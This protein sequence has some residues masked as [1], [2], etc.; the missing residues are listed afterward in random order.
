MIQAKPVD[1][2]VAFLL[3]H[4]PPPMHL[5]IATRED[6]PL[7]PSRLRAR[8][9]LTELRATDL[10]FTVTEAATFLGQVM[11]LDLSAEE[12]IVLETRTEGWIGRPATNHALPVGPSGCARIH[13]GYRRRYPTRRGQHRFPGPDGSD[14]LDS[15]RYPLC[16][17]PA[18]V[19]L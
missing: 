14:R 1:D 6:P 13:P 18:S 4:R 19:G 9:Q 16:E 3:A 2:T 15:L 10:R 8:G 5:A 7:P 11:A 17:G 12:V